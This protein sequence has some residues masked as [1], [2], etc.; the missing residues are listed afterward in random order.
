M[1][2]GTRT[3]VF[4]ADNLVLGTVFASR[5]EIIELLGRGGMG[6]VYKAYDRD[7]RET[8]ALKLLRPDAAS[9]EE[10]LQRF[11]NEMKLARTIGHRYVCRMHDLGTN[12]GLPYLTMEY[13]AGENLRDVLRKSGPLPAGRVVAIGQQIGEG[14]A[15]AHRK[16]VIHRDLKPQNIMI[17]ESGC[18]RIM[19]FGIARP[20]EGHNLTREGVI[21]GTPEYMSPEQWAGEPLDPRTDIYALG[22]ILYEMAT[23]RPPFSGETAFLL[24]LK[25]RSEAPLDPRSLNP[26]VP[27]GL[28]DAILA[29][30][31]K[32]RD[33]RCRT[34]EDFLA[35]MGALS[36]SLNRPGAAAVEARTKSIA[37]LPF[38]DL[39]PEKDQEYFCDGIAE[40]LLTALTKIK[41]V[42]VAA[43]TSAFAFKGRTS[44][45]REIG[46]RLNVGTILE[47]SV[48]K[49]GTKLRI[50]AQLVDVADGFHIWSER[51]DRDLVDIFAIQDEV[52][53]A[54]IDHLAL[55]LLPQEQQAVFTRG[56]DNL[57][58][59]NDYLKGL[60]YL[61]SY[62]SRGFEEAIRCFEAA[63]ARDPRYARAYW[64]LSDAYLQVAF[65][66]NVSPD[67][68]CGKVKEAAHKALEIDP[69]LG[70]AHGALSY[71]YTIHDWNWAAAEAEARE[72]VRLSP[73]SAMVHA[74]YSWFL[75]N[76]ERFAEG[77]AEAL[78]AKAL[79]PVS[80]FIAFAAGLAFS[81]SGDYGRAIEEFQAGIRMNPDFYILQSHLGT[82]Y[83]ASGRYGEAVRAHEKAVEISG[84]VPYITAQLALAYYQ[85]GRKEEADRIYGEL[86]ERSRLE[87]VPSVCFFQMCL[88]RGQ[89]GAALRW[90]RKAGRE[91]DSYLSWLRVMPKE[92]IQ[93]PDEARIKTIMKKAG[94]KSIIGRTLAR[95]R[96]LTR[97]VARA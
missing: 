15:E 71:V 38:T 34:A 81:M 65:W 54:I 23:G 35:L 56:T 80:S 37:V 88:V 61:W 11:R 68:A 32:E 4:P 25:H 94:I 9:S 30:L 7:L 28:A 36:S 85:A 66:G 78:K 83:Y 90:L 31:E 26:A 39:S 77:V 96:I 6:T 41:N 17:D 22:A 10:M 58:A 55:T 29:C 50:T 73:N 3:S 93:T 75:L 13:V 64:G 48:R 92:Y 67:L 70:D 52:T 46:R 69:S 59:H 60:H 40:E 33:R 79:D 19:D 76:T 14:L 82:A 72:A 49:A 42:H 12:D 47:G 16:G 57:E 45:V 97:P 89:I 86:E 43:R 24:G 53:A 2:S 44:D 8:I 95:H 18:A 63:I 21:I 5:Y 27:E 87:Y 74:Y 20:I 62:S 51:Y 1:D 91:H 84:R